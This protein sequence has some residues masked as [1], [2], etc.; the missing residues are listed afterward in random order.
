MVRIKLILKAMWKVAQDFL[1]CAQQKNPKSL[2]DNL[3]TF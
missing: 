3:P 1:L 2:G